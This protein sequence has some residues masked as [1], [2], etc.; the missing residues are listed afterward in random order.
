MSS[1]TEEIYLEILLRVPVRSTFTCKCVCK[2]WFSIISNPSFVK[3]HLN[4]TIQR[5]NPTL[6]LK[7]CNDNSEDEFTNAVYSIGYDTLLSPVTDS[8]DD[9]FELD[10][11]FKPLVNYVNLKG[12]CN[13]LLCLGYGNDSEEFFCLWNPATKEIK[14]IPKSPTEYE[15][16]HSEVFDFVYDW[17]TDDYK[18]IILVIFEGD[19]DRC[20][21]DVYSLAS[22]SWRVNKPP[23]PYMFPFR[24]EIGE[25]VNGALHWLCKTPDGC[26]TLVISLDVSDE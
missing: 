15:D 19:K 5:N 6:M 11:P 16:V 4:L 23:P 14:I 25:I 3:M 21:V 18:L 20:L 12:S 17:K 1:V 8:A 24:R 2:T 13:G 9:V 7:G 26:S 10:D 22:N